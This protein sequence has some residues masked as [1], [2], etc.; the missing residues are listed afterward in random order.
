MARRNYY[1]ILGITQ[2]ESRSGIKK[3]YRRLAR[4]YHPD[5]NPGDKSSEERFKEI[6]EAYRVLDD[7]KKRKVYDRYGYY[8]EG[9]RGGE[10]EEYRDHRGFSGF[11]FG[12]ARSGS[13][14]TGFRDIFSDLFGSRDAGGSGG[15]PTR[16]SDLE[17][18]IL[19]PFLE[20]IRGTQTRL[21]LS[22]Q[23]FC[24]LCSGSG[25]KSKVSRRVCPT[26]R[27]SGQVQPMRGVMRFSTPCSNCRG[28]GKVRVGDCSGCG[29]T[30]RIQKVE[31]L[32]VRIPPGVHSG[33]RIRVARKG[34]SGEE[35]SAPGDL[36]LVVDVEPHP[37]FRRERNNI[38]C[39]IPVTV[40]EAA[41]GSQIEVPTVNGRARL[42]IP[43]GT[44]SGQ[45]FRLKGRG[46][47]SRRNGGRGDQL[48]EVRI[49]L[50]EIRDERS[51]ELLREF[52]ALNPQDP[53]AKIGE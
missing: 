6:Q 52:A 11:D 44:Q 20:A 51:K 32:R 1:D 21:N 3:A 45:K 2:G 12:G 9:P 33:S 26:C 27:G 42:K 16:G 40:T 24:S 23:E 41:L 47:A 46:V 53:R 5:V 10:P 50:P 31:T 7:P 48:V 28:K 18:R 49:V 36:F 14:Q 39:S 38:L 37:F 15:P 30:G 34:D 8:R 13:W 43:P 29:G 19:I 17:S 35:G 25:T 22:R 4:K